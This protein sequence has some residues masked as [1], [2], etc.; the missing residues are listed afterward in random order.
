MKLS[1][2]LFAFLLPLAWAIPAAQDAD[3]GA[4]AEAA[5]GAGPGPGGD[6]GDG[7]AALA[8]GGDRAAGAARRITCSVRGTGVRYRR[9]PST[10]N[11]RCPA[12]GQYRNGQRVTFVCITTGTPVF[13]NR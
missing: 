2:I 5:D 10:D 8:D 6:D 1:T 3:D 7:A 12:I 11:R 4:P 9:C 13:G